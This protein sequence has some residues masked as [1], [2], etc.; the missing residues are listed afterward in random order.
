V[1]LVIEI[2]IPAN[3]QESP[4]RQ[5]ADVHPSPR[6]NRIHEKVASL[7]QVNEVTGQNQA[8]GGVILLLPNPHHYLVY[9]ELN[10]LSIADVDCQV[11]ANHA[12]QLGTAAPP[13][14]AH[15]LKNVKNG[16]NPCGKNAE[17]RAYSKQ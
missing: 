7:V 3:H 17:P 13:R 15:S 8:V 2:I 4:L 6:I 10:P 16:V 12:E 5:N 14:H 1:P 11:S 9:L